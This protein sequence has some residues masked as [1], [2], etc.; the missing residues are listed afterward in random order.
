M[1]IDLF[2][3]SWPPDMFY[4]LVKW[5]FGTHWTILTRPLPPSKAQNAYFIRALLYKNRAETVKNHKN[6]VKTIF[7]F[8]VP[9]TGQSCPSKRPWV[10][11][12]RFGFKIDISKS[13][14][15]SKLPWRP[16]LKGRFLTKIG[17]KWTRCQKFPKWPRFAQEASLGANRTFS[18][19]KYHSDVTP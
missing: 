8:K 3:L 10:Q 12:R 5:H 11:N 18:A 14:P 16:I 9:Q 2:N 19:K 1:N 7:S 17:Q 4:Y 13:H 6:K 15:N